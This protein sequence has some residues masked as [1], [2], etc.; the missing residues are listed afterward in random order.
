MVTE[1]P[2]GCT[3]DANEHIAD[4]PSTANIEMTEAEPLAHTPSVNKDRHSAMT[5]NADLEHPETAVKIFTDAVRSL[6]KEMKTI[7][8]TTAP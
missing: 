3:I 1:D 2:V 4:P 8:R 5:C 7:E 6:L